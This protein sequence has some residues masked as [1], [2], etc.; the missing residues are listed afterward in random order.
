MA[1][2]APKIACF[3]RLAVTL[4][5]LLVF[6]GSAAFTQGTHADWS[7]PVD[8]PGAGVT[9]G[10]IVTAA[11]ADGT[12]AM[13]W[14]DGE[15]VMAS[16]KPSGAGFGEPKQ[17]GEGS[18]PRVEVDDAGRILVAWISG[19]D[20]ALAERAPNGPLIVA[21][22]AM[23][24]PGLSDISLA[25]NNAG[26][27]LIA[28]VSP[29]RRGL[30]TRA[31]GE[32]SFAPAWST[33]V[34]DTYGRLQVGVGSG[35][36]SAS[37]VWSDPVGADAGLHAVHWSAA[38]GAGPSQLLDTFTSGLGPGSLNQLEIVGGDNP[39]VLYN[40]RFTGLGEALHLK[41]S[42]ATAGSFGPAQ[43]LLQNSTLIFPRSVPSLA[44][45]KVPGGGASIA[46]RTI[47]VD[48][49]VPAW[50]Y[51]IPMFR[52][53]GSGLGPADQFLPPAPEAVDLLSL[54]GLPDG[55]TAVLYQTETEILEREQAADG[56]AEPD[57]STIA[58]VDEEMKLDH[59][60]VAGDHHGGL[61]AA[62]VRGTDDGDR[63]QL[64]M[65]DEEAPGSTIT[66]PATTTVGDPVRFSVA[67]DRW[68]PFT[69]SWS[70]GD[71]ASH[72]GP[73]ISHVYEEPGT[74]E[75]STTVTDASG[76][77]DTAIHSIQVTPRPDPGPNPVAVLS[78]LKIKGPAKIKKGRGAVFTVKV[79]NSGN[80]TATGVMVKV[81]GKGVTAKRSAGSILARK[82]KSVKLRVKPKKT[83]TVTLR[84][85]V[86]A[87]NAAA[88][89]ARKKV[90]V[91]RPRSQ[92]LR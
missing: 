41:A 53:D 19:N 81:S 80:A 32:R 76:H 28:Y 78:G 36:D 24:A 8:V 84:F 61:F 59:V 63:I 1:D 82:S 3:R 6:A 44:V 65:Y 72:T 88:K 58:D 25:F 15:N 73:S 51:G 75:I 14:T 90:K 70:T 12:A 91:L 26:R 54:G 56:S 29:S 74:Y 66:G 83:G 85:S 42:T 89:S 39:T 86:S 68:S 46:W 33:S 67:G 77:V 37:T 30:V 50:N 9:A 16:V 5:G 22:T 13:V 27:G 17:L 45:A 62:W 55:R 52:H 79:A 31:P 10:S 71:G 11:G 35:P 64:A 47:T 40:V 92:R 7:A 20:V 34:E 23:R 2:P 87:S 18:T 43:T 49:D 38:T 69:V 4:V 48:P 21:G 60:E 57:V